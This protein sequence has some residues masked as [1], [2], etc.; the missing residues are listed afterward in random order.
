MTLQDCHEFAQK[1]PM[2]F[3]ATQDGDQPRVRAFLFWFA[4]QSGFYFQTLA[5]K[6]V[7]LQIRANP[8]V[9]VCF[10]NNGDLATIRMLRVT[11]AAE[12]CDNPELRAKLL[13]D[14]PFLATVGDVK[15][16]PIFQVFRVERRGRVLD[17]AGYFA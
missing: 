13:L 11:G 17:D 10:S 3:L 12:F 5:S 15:K 9:E 8:K 6:D 14:M 4:D 16:D 7:C 1:N 2:C